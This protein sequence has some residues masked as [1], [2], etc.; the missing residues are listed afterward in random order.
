MTDGDNKCPLCGK[1]TDGEEI[2]CRDCQEIA[3]NTFSTE[4]IDNE[5]AA[6][7]S[8][9]KE[10]DTENAETIPEENIESGVEEKPIRRSNKGWFIFAGICIFFMLSVGIGSYFF[11]ENKNEEETEIAYWRQCVIENSPLGYS[12]YLVQ[13]PEGKFSEEAHNKIAELRNKE[14]NEW[15]KLRNSNDVDALFAFLTDHPQTPYASE[16]RHVIDS[17]SWVKTV[18]DNTADA[19]LAYLENVEI[20]RYPGE[21]QTQAQE[22]YDYLSQLKTVEG[23]ALDSVKAVVSDFFESLSE[24]NEKN[25]RK[26]IASALSQFFEADN[27]SAKMIVDSIKVNFKNNKIKEIVYTPVTD[28]IEVIQDNKGLYLITLPLNIEKSYTDRKLKKEISKDTINVVLNNKKLVQSIY[29]K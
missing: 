3:Q 21:Y 6:T 26:N 12:K 4:L 23:A 10:A 28:S 25:L 18:E 29:R 5:P 16:I 14:R 27:Q 15:E 13:Y 8:D 24:A 9:G 17:L 7:V 11:I 22:R 2:F 1:N 19:Y 20:E